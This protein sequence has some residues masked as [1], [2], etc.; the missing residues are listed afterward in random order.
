[1]LIEA[2]RR[3]K[4]HEVD[5]HGAVIK[6]LPDENNRFVADVQD[7]NSIRRLLEITEGYRALGSAAGE[8]RDAL[9][10]DNE[11]D[12]GDD[13]PYLL[14]VE[15]ENGQEKTIDL[16]TLDRAQLE[17]FMEQNEIPKIP[18]RAKDETLR[19]KIIAFFRG[20]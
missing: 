4:P 9:D 8:V 3:T 19:N 14:T 11:D 16:R 12:G 7:E 10:G 13:S 6:F 5:L 2:Y 18:G 17:D 1:M 20:A 15:G